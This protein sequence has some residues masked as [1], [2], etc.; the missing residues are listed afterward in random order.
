MQPEQPQPQAAGNAAP[1]QDPEQIRGKIWSV[2]LF[3]SGLGLGMMFTAGMFM[4]STVMQEHADNMHRYYTDQ[5]YE[6]QIAV[7]M[8]TMDACQEQCQN[9]ITAAVATARDEL[10]LSMGKDFHAALPKLCTVV[11]DDQQRNSRPI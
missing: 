10:T 4:S 11:V 3:F 9:R 6:K 2:M 8:Q 5:C 7:S 1:A